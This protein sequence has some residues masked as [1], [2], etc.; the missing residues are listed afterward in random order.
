ML[1]PEAARRDH[2]EAENIATPTID[3]V[4][5]ALVPECPLPRSTSRHNE[6]SKRL[7]LIRTY[8]VELVLSWKE[9]RCFLYSLKEEGKGWITAL[10]MGFQMGCESLWR[11]QSWE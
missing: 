3:Q 7:R 4:S 8:E 9:F 10:Y 6:N 2:S 11:K 5:R 1:G